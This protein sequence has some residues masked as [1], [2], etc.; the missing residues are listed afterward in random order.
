MMACI[1]EAE[2]DAITIDPSEL[3]T[4]VRNALTVK[5]YHDS[6]RHHARMLEE[7][8]QAAEQAAR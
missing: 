6:L 1:A 3:V 7:A 5:K 8:V 2:D 4:R